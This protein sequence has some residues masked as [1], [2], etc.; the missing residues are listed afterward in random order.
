MAELSAGVE[1]ER[2]TG[3]RAPYQRSAFREF[4][5]RRYFAAEYT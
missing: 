3:R 1:R 5:K 2:P 4:I